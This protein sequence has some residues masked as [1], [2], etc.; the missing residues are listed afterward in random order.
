[1]ASCML[2]LHNMLKLS[3]LKKTTWQASLI[4]FLLLFSFQI[5]EIQG[6]ALIIEWFIPLLDS[7][8]RFYLEEEILIYACRV[9]QFAC[10]MREVHNF[11]RAKP[12]NATVFREIGFLFEGEVTTYG[13]G[14]YYWTISVWLHFQYYFKKKNMFVYVE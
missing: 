8:T 13:E 1:M 10:P 4:A 6:E 9:L 14:I 5:K 12:K 2:H 3:P 11:V 7:P